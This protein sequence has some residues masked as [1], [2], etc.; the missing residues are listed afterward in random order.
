MA[1]IPVFPP[2]IMPEILSINTVEGLVPEIPANRVPKESAIRVRPKFLGF[3][4]G[5]C[6]F[7]DSHKPEAQQTESNMSVKNNRYRGM[8]SSNLNIPVK[9]KANIVEKSGSENEVVV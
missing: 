9:L 5:V 4:S 3:P 7:P 8:S 6:S 2:S 1:A